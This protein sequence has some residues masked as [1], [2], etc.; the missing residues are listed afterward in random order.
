MTTLSDLAA[1]L[2][3]SKS[4]VSRSFSRPESVGAATR[5][6]VLALAAELGYSPDPTARSLATGRTHAVG[7]LVPDLANPVHSVSVKSARAT[8]F[9]RGSTLL[10]ADREEQEADDSSTIAALS[11]R[12]DGLVLVLPRLSDAGL[13]GVA[14]ATPTVL[15]HRDVTGIPGVTASS[16]AALDDAVAHLAR[17]GHRRIAYLAGPRDTLPGVER[18]LAVTASAAR[19]GLDLTELGPYAPRLD[20]GLRAGADVLATTATAALAYND[21]IAVGLYRGLADAGVRVGV[22]LSVI[23]HDGIWAADYLEPPLA[24]VRL[25]ADRIVSTAIDLLHDLISGTGTRADLVRLDCSFTAARSA[26][27]AP[28]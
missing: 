24:T 22:D 14:A 11:R 26:A 10:V 9:G 2:G 18:R 8:A 16:E 6:R 15:V 19:H 4:T 12:V 21:L 3:V 13:L 5:E 27:I 1:R 17:L 25:P 7:V 20:E 28:R 23:G